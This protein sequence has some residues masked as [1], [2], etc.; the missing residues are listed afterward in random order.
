[1][2]KIGLFLRGMLDFRALGACPLCMQVSFAAMVISWMLLTASAFADAGMLGM[3]FL[4]CAVFT[5]LW[6]AHVSARAVRTLPP[7]QTEQDARRVALRAFGRAVIGAAVLSTALFS[8]PQPAEA[9]ECGQ[10]C[11]RSNDNCPRGCICWWE[12]KRCAK[13]G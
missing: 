6:L 7:R 9:A 3:S 8:K 2:K 4:L 11:S 1:M 13:L 10:S 5:A 12:L